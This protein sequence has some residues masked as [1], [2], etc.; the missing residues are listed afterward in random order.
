LLLLL[1]L[2]FSA[3]VANAIGTAATTNRKMLN[4]R[5]IYM[6][7]VTE[8]KITGEHIYVSRNQIYKMLII[9]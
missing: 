2:L 5:V 9:A 3:D 6:R 8:L 4:A 7:K 1:L